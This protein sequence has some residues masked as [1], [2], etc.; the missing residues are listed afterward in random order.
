MIDHLMDKSLQTLHTMS[1]QFLNGELPAFVKNADVA[2][3]KPAAD[4]PL[5][6]YGDAV[7]RRF[8]CHTKVAT[9]LSCLYFWGRNQSEKWASACPVD[10]VADR[11]T[12]AAQ[13]WGILPDVQNLQKVITEKSAS[14]ERKLEDDDYALIV[15]YG[16]ER[17]R[18]FPIVNATTIKKAA[19]NLYRF[20]M[21]YPYAWR[22]K[23]ANKILERAMKYNAQPDPVH[24]DYLVKASGA[25]PADNAEVASKLQLRS[26]VFPDEIRERMRK[27]AD[28][29]VKNAG[30]KISK[31]CELLDT[32]DRHYKK[33][34]MYNAPADNRLEMPEEVC[35]SGLS[36]KLAE[37]TP[38]VQLTTGST[39]A[40]E[41]IKKA[42][43]EPFSLLPAEYLTSIVANDKGDLDMAKVADVLPTIPKD[44][45]QTL[46]RTLSAVGV[47]PMEKEAMV[48]AA[49]DVSKL[50]LK[51]FSD[52]LGAPKDS[53]FIAKFQLKHAQ[54]MHDE[55]EEKQKD[56]RR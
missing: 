51:G 3:E 21:S 33:Y 35:Y 13:Y 27:V 23:A 52:V 41:D 14:P 54:G 12:K 47:K 45:A 30:V 1:K 8:P 43:L 56:S 26:Y 10:M 34:A 9:W 37:A 55:L 39:F 15:N 20:R 22:K 6:V 53:D 24:L 18:R 5:T 38:S 16:N 28:M 46:E 32:V 2:N 48:K 49:F 29:L 40:L 44:D 19:A 50:S 11:L 25:Y 31:I 36:V 7:N 42:G 4:A 17:I